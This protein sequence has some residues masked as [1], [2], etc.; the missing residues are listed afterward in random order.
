MDMPVNLKDL[1]LSQYMKNPPGIQRKFEDFV[2]KV[3]NLNEKLECDDE[4]FVKKSLHIRRLSELFRENGFES[5]DF[6]QEAAFLKTC[7]RTA[8]LMVFVDIDESEK[9]FFKTTQLI[10]NGISNKLLQDRI[11]PINRHKLE[12]FEIIDKYF[13]AYNQVSKVLKPEL[14]EALK[15]ILNQIKYDDSTISNGK[16]NCCQLD[17]AYLADLLSI[18]AN[19]YSRY[20]MYKET[21][22]ALR[23]VIKIYRTGIQGE[24]GKLGEVA[25]MHLIGIV[26]EKMG[27]YDTA[28]KTHQVVAKME[29]PETIFIHR[30]IFYCGQISYKQEN[31]KETIEALQGFLSVEGR[32]AEKFDSIQFKWRDLIESDETIYTN[33]IRMLA[34]S[35]IFLYLKSDFNEDYIKHLKLATKLEM[36]KNKGREALLEYVQTCREIEKLFEKV[37]EKIN[38]IASAD[39][40]HY[41]KSR[42][43]SDL[44]KVFK[45]YVKHAFECMAKWNFHSEIKEYTA[46]NLE[47]VN[48]HDDEHRTAKM[49]KIKDLIPPSPETTSSGGENENQFHENFR[50]KNDDFTKKPKNHSDVVVDWKDYFMG[51]VHETMKNLVEPCEVLVEAEDNIDTARFAVKNNVESCL[52]E[53]CQEGLDKIEAAF[54]LKTKYY[55]EQHGCSTLPTKEIIEYYDIVGDLHWKLQNPSNSISREKKN[56]LT[57]VYICVFFLAIVYIITH[58]AVFGSAIDDLGNKLVAFCTHQSLKCLFFS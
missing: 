10:Q 20:K 42:M 48:V 17:L 39:N 3:N 11:K 38:P 58:I 53:K 37:D 18:K 12:I 19:I 33:A 24:D 7:L 15:P 45:L 43:R 26:H 36:E 32:G 29:V 56:I 49:Y 16:N 44:T 14:I 25:F 30:S 6:R 8:G 1:K 4:H 57:K 40:F 5:T 13:I 31:Y 22:K 2:E 28:Y 54:L 47:L 50:E 41:T 9:Y 51:H 52:E 23:K 27:N 55:L 21:V 46:S 34:E 35:R